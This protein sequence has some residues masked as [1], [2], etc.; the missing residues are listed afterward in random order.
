MVL[1]EVGP[2]ELEVP[3]DRSGTFEPIIVPK[4]RRRL[5]GV[6]ALVC[7]LAAKGLTHG[8]ICAHLAEIYGAQVSKET[9]T[10]IT[11]RV[12][13]GMSE[14]QNRPLDCGLPGHLRRRHPRK[15]PRG[16]G[17]QPAR[18]T[19]PSAVTVDGD[20][21]HLW[22]C[23]SATAARAPS[24]GLHVLTETQEPRRTGDV[25]LVVCDGLTGPARRGGLGVA[26]DH[27]A[28]RASST[29]LRN[30]FPLRQPQGLAGHRQGPQA[31]LHR[32][33]RGRPPWTASPSSPSAGRPATR[34]SSR[35]WENAWAEFVPFLG[36]DATR[37]GTVIYTT[38]AIES[39]NA[40][41][42]K[43]GQGPWSF[44][45]QRT[46]RAQVRLSGPHEPRSQRARAATLDQPL[47]AGA[48]RLR[49]G[50]PGSYPEI[51]PLSSVGTA[52]G[53][54]WS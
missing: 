14:W 25:C 40:R 36:F 50:V 49:G 8:E 10:R 22:V 39:V 24:T 35:L 19:W 4:R 51:G 31:H 53:G 15:D 33:D 47:E 7:S 6:D 41:I 5:N 28:G 27:R 2:I 21:R 38:N 12:I 44:P 29:Y 3:R 42:R 48:Q 45:R 11:D 9:I 30:E 32:P 13:E 20:P 16:P 26:A 17:G 52:A 54:W 46:G 34:P 43:G 37:S 23:G 1:T 18:S